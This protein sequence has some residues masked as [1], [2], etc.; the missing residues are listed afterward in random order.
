MTTTGNQPEEPI[1]ID[2]PKNIDILSDFCDRGIVTLNADFKNAV[3]LG[4]KALILLSRPTD[5][6]LIYARGLLLSQKER[7]DLGNHSL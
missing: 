4:K 6:R 1:S 2:I 5:P 3:K 7:K